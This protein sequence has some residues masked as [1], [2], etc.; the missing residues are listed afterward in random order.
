MTAAGI[1]KSA[2]ADDAEAKRYHE[3]LSEYENA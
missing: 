1:R 3:A 2:E